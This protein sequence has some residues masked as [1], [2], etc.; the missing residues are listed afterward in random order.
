M[1]RRSLA[2]A[3]LLALASPALADDTGYFIVRLGQDTT[4]IEHYTRTANRVTVEQT[5]KSASS[6]AAVRVSS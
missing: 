4:A 6:S 1:S 5:G 3:L 2:T